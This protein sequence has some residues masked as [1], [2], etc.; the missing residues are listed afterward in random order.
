MLFNLVKLMAII[1]FW[2]LMMLFSIDFSITQCSLKEKKSS[3]LLLHK[4]PQNN[5]KNTY[6][7]EDSIHWKCTK[8]SLQSIVFNSKKKSHLSL[9]RWLSKKFLT[10]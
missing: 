3:C 10:Y 7:E 4:G 9:Q 6:A 2:L 5:I 8:T 1:L